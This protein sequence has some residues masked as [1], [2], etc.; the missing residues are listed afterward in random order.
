MKRYFLLVTSMALLSGCVSQTRCIVGFSPDRAD[1][2]IRKDWYGLVP[3]ICGFVTHATE[4]CTFRLPGDKVVYRGEEV[5][6]FPTQ[7]FPYGGTISVFR[8]K[9]R[10]VIDLRRGDSPFEYNGKYR[11]E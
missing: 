6:Q 9:K 8:D 4:G 3:G 5:E 1:I 7:L 10:V 11:Y 2:Q